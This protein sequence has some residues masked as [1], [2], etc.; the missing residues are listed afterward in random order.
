MITTG[1]LN[2]QDMI[3]ILNQWRHDFS[4]KHLWGGYCMDIVL[5]MSGGQ[6][7][8]FCKTSSRICYI[9]L[10]EYKCTCFKPFFQ[11]GK[12]W[13]HDKYYPLKVEYIFEYNFWIMNHF[14]RK[15]DQV[16]DLV[17][18]II[19]KKYFA[20]F[21]GLYPKSRPIL[22]YQTNTLLNQSWWVF[23]FLIF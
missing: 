12:L 3:R 10:F 19:F 14:V 13:H 20:W 5:F 16:K 2:S 23:G 4:D 8:W 6:N 22:I 1:S 7:S 18:C 11:L 21:G 9:N 15:C 17:K